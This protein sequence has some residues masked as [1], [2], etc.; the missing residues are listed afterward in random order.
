MIFNYRQMVYRYRIR[1]FRL[2][3]CGIFFL[4]SACTAETYPEDA[5]QQTI[6]ILEDAYQK[7]AALTPQEKQQFSELNTS[8]PFPGL[9]LAHKKALLPEN[10]WVPQAV[11]NNPSW[12]ASL[13][14]YYRLPDGAILRSVVF[15]RHTDS[16]QPQDFSVPAF[17]DRLYRFSPPPRWLETAPSA[18][19]SLPVASSQTQQAA[20]TPLPSTVSFLLSFVD[21]N[22]CLNVGKST[23]FSKVL[24]LQSIS[25]SGLPST[26]SRVRDFSQNQATSRM[27]R[28]ALEKVCS[29]AG[30]LTAYN[31]GTVPIVDMWWEMKVPLAAQTLSSAP[32]YRSSPQQY[33]FRAQH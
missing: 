5:H 12:M 9:A 18:E 24:Y 25:V 11:S 6:Q 21:K 27:D 26:T 19:A 1:V 32:Y 13:T 15:K 7:F 29:Q 4:V 14:G 20:A 33:Q 23:L 31:T 22:A 2:A 8:E 30:A 16:N 17:G 28:L 3:L 10:Y